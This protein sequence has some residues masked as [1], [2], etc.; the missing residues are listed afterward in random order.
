MGQDLPSCRPLPGVGEI[1]EVSIRAG[2]DT[3]G[4][5]EFLSSKLLCIFSYIYCR[6]RCVSYCTMGQGY[7]C[8]NG[9]FFKDD[10][11]AS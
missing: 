3:K 4:P 7:L 9:S 5:G 8:R 6:Q 2:G 10:M 11:I 1:S